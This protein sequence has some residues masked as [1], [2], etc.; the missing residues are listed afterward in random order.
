MFQENM[1]YFMLAIIL[2]VFLELLLCFSVYF[3]ELA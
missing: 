3:L 2:T 1:K